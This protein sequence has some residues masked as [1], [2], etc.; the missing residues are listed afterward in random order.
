MKEQIKK[1]IVILFVVLFVVTLTASVVSAGNTHH[2]TFGS[3]HIPT[4]KYP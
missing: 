1:T 4:S 3:K 2:P